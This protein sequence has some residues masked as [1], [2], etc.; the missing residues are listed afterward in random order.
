MLIGTLCMIP[1]VNPE[2]SIIFLH[3]G[4]IKQYSYYY[5]M[6]QDP[7]IWLP[8]DSNYSTSSPTKQQPVS[9]DTQRRE[10]EVCT[11]YFKL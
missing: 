5:L 7:P 8:S 1:M 3:T 11:R 6:L 9:G 2:Q 10:V 4:N